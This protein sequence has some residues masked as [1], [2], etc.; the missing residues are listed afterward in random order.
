MSHHRIAIIADIHGNVPALT[1]VLTDLERLGPDEVL[2]GGDLVGRGPQ[3]SA[4][5]EL[6]RQRGWPSVRGNHEDY[7]LAF[8]QRRIPEAWWSDDEWAAARWMTAEL[9]HDDFVYLDSLPMTLASRAVPGL[10]LTHGSPRSH[11]EGLGPWTSDVKL[12]AL[13]ERMDESLLACAHTHRQ[14]H[15]RLRA[16]EVVNVGSVGL[17]FDGDP[18]AQYVILEWTGGRWNVEMRRVGYDI[19]ELF[20][21]YEESGFAAAGGATVELL[22]LEIEHAAP[23]LV[24]FL[25][26]SEALGTAPT[27]DR[28][29]DFLDLYDP[30]EPVHEFFVRLEASTKDDP[31]RSD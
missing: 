14:M 20:T 28:I 24:P 17:P 25:K 5:I 27:R 6:I 30:G 4:V 23:F 9:S 7:L 16:G 29:A 3:G 19:E 12:E 11:S 8:H 13:L 26:W 22:R 21:I 15:R 1:A 18:R 10:L 2:V 31:H